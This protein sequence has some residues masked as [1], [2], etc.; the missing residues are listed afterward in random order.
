MRFA[1][2]WVVVGAVLAAGGGFAG[3]RL[4]LGGA[5]AATAGG[6][7]DLEKTL[8][9]PAGVS[10]ATPAGKEAMALALKL[11]RATPR[12]LAGYFREEMKRQPADDLKLRFLLMRWS[13]V[14]PAGCLEAMAAAGGPQAWQPVMSAWMDRDAKAAA[15]WFV[16]HSALIPPDQRRTLA[17]SLMMRSG[18]ERLFAVDFGGEESG[19]ESADL[20]TNFLLNLWQSA[21]A[22]ALRRIGTPD[23]PGEYFDQASQLM[24]GWA[25]QDPEAVRAWVAL[26][27]DAEKR[28]VLMGAAAAGYAETDLRRAADWL[29]SEKVATSHLADAMGALLE[30]WG[31]AAPL[32]AFTWCRA[33]GEDGSVGEETLGR[34]F[35][36]A[37]SKKGLAKTLAQLTETGF[38]EAAQCR[39]CRNWTG[40]DGWELNKSLWSQLRGLPEGKP[41]AILAEAVARELG[42]EIASDAALAAELTTLTDSP[43]ERKLL[44]AVTLRARA[45]SSG[46][47]GLAMLRDPSQP[48]T[49]DHVYSTAQMRPAEVAEALMRRTDATPEQFSQLISGWEEVDPAAAARWVQ[50][51][52]PSPN[53][54]SAAGEMAYYWASEDAAAASEWVAALPASAERDAAVGG[55]IRGWMGDLEYAA[56]SLAWAA[57]IQQKNLRQQMVSQTVES[58]MARDP[59]AAAA[60]LRASSLTPDE[61]TNLLRRAGFDP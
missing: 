13:Q 52:P 58:W 42:W 40:P 21:P 9:L 55:L 16:E 51:L 29:A 44:E 56:E 12:E 10:D 24:E 46:E 34:V 32:E 37:A 60:A 36:S 35:T 18:D 20:R 6:A 2:S 25:R 15:A 41:R 39:I 5:G 47:A 11:L 38:D 28:A 45:D 57:S 50:A 27:K 7:V 22:E 43:A 33:S 49:A 19:S 30:R 54:R 14:D 4:A 53:A 3:R 59:A 48:V 61:K 17:S 8:T 1:A 23:A 31:A 26:E